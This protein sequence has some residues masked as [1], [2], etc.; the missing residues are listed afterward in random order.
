MTNNLATSLL[1]RAATGNDIIAILDTIVDMVTDQN[2]DECAAHYA[3]ISTPTSEPIAF[4][5]T[6]HSFVNTA[7]GGY[8][9][10][11]CVARRDAPRI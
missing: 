7:V 3:A 1:N 5:Y 9:A 10:P 2:I 6:V 8:Y 4:W 11:L